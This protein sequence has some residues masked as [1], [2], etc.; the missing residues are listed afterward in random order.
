MSRLLLIKLVN[1][2][3]IEAFLSIYTEKDGQKGIIIGKGAKMV[4]RIRLQAQYELSRF[5]KRFTRN[6]RKVNLL[7]SNPKILQKLR[8]N[9][10]VVII[11]LT[12]R[13][14]LYR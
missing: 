14:R 11:R 13:K 10:E 3:K 7:G 4:K 1:Q 8:I 6:Y 9:V 2:T 5:L 12:P